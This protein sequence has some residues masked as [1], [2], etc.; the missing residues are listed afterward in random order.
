MG[1]WILEPARCFSST[2]LDEKSSSLPLSQRKLC[3]KEEILQNLCLTRH[4][5]DHHLFG[6]VSNAQHLKIY[7]CVCVC[8]C[9][10]AG[11]NGGGGLPS[12]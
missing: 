4:I 7:L 8:M 9:C 2:F 5:H 12:Q 1:A 10:R 11:A 6:F 3:L